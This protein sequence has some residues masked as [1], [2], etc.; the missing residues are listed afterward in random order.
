[1]QIRQAKTKKDFTY[2]ASLFNS[3]NNRYIW[4][5]TQTPKQVEQNCSHIRRYYLLLI[6]K[7]PVG[8]FNIRLADTKEA[9]IGMIIDKPHQGKGFGK[10][11]MVLIKK[12]AKTLGMKKLRLEVFVDNKPAVNLYKKSGFKTTAKVLVMEYK[13]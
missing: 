3:K 5:K 12:E 9:T 11:A 6:D 1:M 4:P 7:K 10:Q 13:F 2:V 8:W